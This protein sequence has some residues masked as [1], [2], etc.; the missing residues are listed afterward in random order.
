M[1]TGQVPDFSVVITVYNKGAFIGQAIESVLNQSYRNFEIIIVDDGSTDTTKNVIHSFSDNRIRYIY[2]ENSGL[3]A[4]ARNAGMMLARGSYIALLDGDDFWHRNKLYECKKVLD[5]NKDISLVCHNEYVLYDGK[6]LRHTS[7]APYAEGMYFRLLFNGNCLYP[8]AVVIRRSIFFD[9]GFNFSEEKNLFTVE[10][11]EYWL[12]LSQRYEFYL[13]PDILGY[14]RVSE[15]GI[16]LTNIDENTKNMLDLLERHFNKVMHKTKEQ[17]NLIHKRYSGVM[18][19]AGRIYQHRKK[20]KESRAW[21]LK[22]I[23]EFPLNYKAGIC[24]LAALLNIRVLY[25]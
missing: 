12:R 20:F 23:K 10:D 24:Y 6:I 9:D 16:Y 5:T 13:L 1:I 2:Q 17:Q 4:C 7:S 3:P 25:R 8:S 22:A 14:Y 18:S 15:G 21:Y 19:A 11:Y